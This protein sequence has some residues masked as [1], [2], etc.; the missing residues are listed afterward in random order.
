MKI[1]YITGHGVA[2]RIDFDNSEQDSLTLIF[3]PYHSGALVLGGKVYTLNDGE[4]TIPVKA[5]QDGEYTPRL[6]SEMGVY[7]AEGFTKQGRSIS[8]LKLD[9]ALVRRLLLRCYNLEKA[10]C[11]LEERVTELELACH[12]HKIFD[13]ERKEK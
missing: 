8:M 12:G 5:L 4:V 7:C 13:F 1:R 9:E 6:E 11:S 2:E 3:E 10:V